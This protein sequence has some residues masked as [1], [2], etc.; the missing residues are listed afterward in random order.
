MAKRRP[1]AS[2]T[3][4]LL[5]VDREA[6]RPLAE[7][8]RPRTLDEM[9]GQKRLLAPTSALRRAVASGRVH[10]MILWGPPGCGKTT[11]ALLLAQYAEAEF[12]AISAVL[13]GLPEVRLVLAEA[14]QRFADGRRT[15]LFVDEV[16]RFNKAQQDA[17]LPHIERGTILFV[18]A[19]TENPSFELNSAL[20][21][22]CRVH[23]LEPVSPQDIAEALQRALH[24]PERGLGAEQLQVSDAALLE[25]AGAADGDVRRALTLLEIAAELAQDEGGEITAQTL[26]QVLADRTRRF[27][28]GGEQFYDQISALHKSVRSSNPDA[29][30]YWLTRMLDGGCDPSYLARRLTRM[31]IEDIGLAD[32]RAQSMALEAWDIYERLGSP[33][34]ELAFAQLV[35]YLA[36]TAKSNAGYAAFNQAKAEV[37]E[38]GTQEVPLHLR[39]APTKLMKTLGYG[40]DYQYDHDAEGGI[41]LDQTGFPD[42]MGERVYYR[43]VERGLE[44]KLKDKLDRLRAAREQARAD[45]A[46]RSAS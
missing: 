6:M 45:K 1:F 14:A 4:D 25:I 37:R 46:G 21:S 5:S 43:P 34:G 15:V 42:A 32:P 26:Q 9:V 11:L 31:A 18:G 19:T 2:D 17:F 36:S 39:N 35:L 41:A 29:A 44:I 24:D 22:R 13:S 20:L 8:M 23:V 33:E 28:K 12:K 40:A 10:S 7:R 3:P 27:D 16:H 30:L 38:T